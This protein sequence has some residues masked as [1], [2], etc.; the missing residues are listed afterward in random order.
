MRKIRIFAPYTILTMKRTSL[1]IIALSLSAA[2]A[3]AQDTIVRTD[4]RSIQAR[5]LEISPSEVRYKRYS[6]PDG[7]TY[8]LP[9]ADIAHIIYQNGERDDFNPAQPAD[10]VS[11]DGVSAVETAAQPDTAA[12][13]A[14]QPAVPAVPAQPAAPRPVPQVGAVYDDN[15]VRGL[16]ISL[17]D[18]GLHG[19]MLSLSE[20]RSPRLLAWSTVRPPYPET[21]ATDKTDGRKNMD[22]VGRYIAEHGLSWDDFPAFKWCRE[23]GEGW[24]LP[25]ID[26]LLTLGARFNGDQRMRYDRKARAHF[27]KTLTDNGGTKLDQ[28]MLYRSSTYTGDGCAATAT[29][30]IEPP[31]VIRCKTR[32]GYAVRAMRRF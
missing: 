7:P 11:A 3:A 24:Y 26:E 12:Q 1:I 27:N 22:A 21:D 30:E 16:V 20:S 29:M 4:A 28:R 25:S 2:T 18:S 8:V 31:F 13:P 14:A 17:D 9:V 32:E 6:N 5:I 10:G 15:G 19:T 23:Q